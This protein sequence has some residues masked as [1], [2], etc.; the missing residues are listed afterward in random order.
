MNKIPA[1]IKRIP[2]ESFDVDDDDEEV[3]IFCFYGKKAK[4]TRNLK[5]F[6]KKVEK[7]KKIDNFFF[8]TIG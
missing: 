4:Q 2:F 8:K 1:A 6:E 3:S 7:V 5:N